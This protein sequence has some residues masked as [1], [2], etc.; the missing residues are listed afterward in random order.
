MPRGQWN[1]LNH[2]WPEKNMPNFAISTLHAEPM[3]Y[4]NICGYSEEEVG[5]PC[6]YETRGPFHQHKLMLIPAWICNYIH[7]DVWDEII[8]PFP[9]FKSVT[10]T[11]FN[12]RNFVWNFNGYLWNST[13][14]ILPIDWKMPFYS[15]ENLRTLIFKKLI[16]LFEMFLIA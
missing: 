5:A 14:N 7:N 9:N 4:C 16:H 2:W 11:S 8:Y 10:Y 13:Q 12:V 3:S 15:V 6:V 1:A